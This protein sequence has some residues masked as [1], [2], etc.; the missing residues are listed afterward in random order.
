MF[1]EGRILFGDV[2]IIIIFPL[3]LGGMGL[4]FFFLP[5][6]EMVALF[7]WEFGHFC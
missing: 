4:L 2:T 3:G 6:L 5:F 1:G 7:I